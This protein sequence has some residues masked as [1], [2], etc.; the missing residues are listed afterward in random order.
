MQNLDRH[1]L[2]NN[3]APVKMKKVKKVSR[4]NSKTDLV[5]EIVSF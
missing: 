4:K 3:Q 1:K 2:L 5:R